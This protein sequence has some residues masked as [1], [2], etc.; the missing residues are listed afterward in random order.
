MYLSDVTEMIIEATNNVNIEWNNLQPQMR[1]V[2]T[3]NENHFH[4]CRYHDNVTKLTEWLA[5]MEKMISAPMQA[6][7]DNVHDGLD[8]FQGISDNEIP[9]M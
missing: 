6:T 1:D 9:E 2:V 8:E 3:N 4:E 7:I 5:K